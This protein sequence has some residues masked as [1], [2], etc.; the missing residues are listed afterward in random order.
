MGRLDGK[1]ALISGALGGQGKEEVKLF[2][3]EG[4]K[5]IFGDL[6]DKKGKELESEVRKYGGEATYIRHDVTQESDWENAVSKTLELYGKLDILI[7]NA[8]VF[9]GKGLEDTTEAEWDL[10]ESV[11]SKGVFLGAKSVISAMKESGAGS[12]INISSIAGLVGTAMAPVYS[13]TKGAVRLLTKSIAVQ[14][15]PDGIRCNS[16]H[17]GIISDTGMGD[18]I[19]EYGIANEISQLSEVPL[20]RFGYPYEVALAVLYLASDESSYV[21]GAELVIDGG[22]FAK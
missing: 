19:I 14:Y 21:T 5:V 15:G 12:I 18:G 4:A 16:V 10:V 11:N 22:R 9:L 1:V 2:C 6:D 3:R 8:G 20:G 7:N 17:P 13:A